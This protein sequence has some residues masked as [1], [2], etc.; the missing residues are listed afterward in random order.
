MCDPRASRGDEAGAHVAIEIAGAGDPTNAELGGGDGGG[1]GRVDRDGDVDVE[2]SVASPDV[3]TVSLRAVQ[4][5]ELALERVTYAPQTRSASTPAA[6]AEGGRKRSL[7]SSVRRGRTAILSDVTTT[8]APGTLSA[9]MGPSGCGKTSLV[10]V[11]AGLTSD[12]AGDLGPDSKVRINGEAG[13]PPRR[14]V[15]V[16]WQDDLLLSNLTVAE[17]VRFAARL[18][19]PRERSDEEVEA[20]VDDTLSK[21]GLAGVRDSLVG[22][23]GG[24]GKSRG[25]SGGERKRVA[26]AVELVARPSVLLLD[27][28]TS[29][30]DASSAYQLVLTLKNLASLGHSIA[31]VIHQPRTSIFNM[32][33]NLLLLSQGRVVYEGA[34]SGARDFLESCPGVGELPPET[35]KADWIMDAINEDESGEGGGKLPSLWE[36]YC[37][38]KQQQRP[39]QSEL[40]E[41]KDGNNP[42]RQRHGA[43]MQP[44][45]HLS[46]RLSTLDELEKSEPKFQSSFWTQLKLLTVRASR[47]QRGQR[48]TLVAAVLTFAW[49]A[50]TCLAWGRIP[51]TTEYVFNR[52]SLLFFLI[53][54]Q[55]NSVVTSTVV[56]FSAERRLLSRERAKKMYGVLPYF[57][58]MTISDMMTSIAM[59]TLYGV[60]TYLICNLRTTASAFFTFVLIMYLTISAAQ[61]TGLFL[62]VLIPN[63]KLALLLA[64]FLTLSLFIIGG[65]YIRYDLISPALAW[66]SWL[67]MARYGF[68]AFVINEFGGR[69]IPCGDDANDAMGECPLPGSAVISSYAIEGAWTSVWLNIGMLIAIQIILRT[70]TYVL[71]RRSK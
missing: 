9:W 20:L 53:I 69:L 29:G 1:G 14:L 40:D 21:L 31:V 65:F 60:I 33:D 8:V 47:Q 35:G 12:P 56:I 50:F 18:K 4:L 59:P 52:V 3:N 11:A 44:R 23:P 54:A 64:P 70:S 63:T 61:S 30:L 34:P 51:D 26:V 22:A 62:S 7:R 19:T 6:N 39:P 38:K 49:S 46:R 45:P 2:A 13:A 43:S 10:S 48:L 32:F 42:L 67:S 24:G 17:T 16:V 58:A 28:P 71:L 5:V 25:I 36:D 41:S 27:E 37:V 15:G 66:A 57:I 55:A 68:S